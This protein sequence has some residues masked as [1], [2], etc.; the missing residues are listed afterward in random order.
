MYKLFEKK[1]LF[2]YILLFLLF[3]L[4]GFH[5]FQH[6]YQSLIA[7]DSFI[8]TFIIKPSSAN[9]HWVQLLVFIVFLVMFYLLTIVFNQ[10]S[11]TSKNLLAIQSIF[12]INSILALYFENDL[13]S[14]F[15]LFFVLLY[16]MFFVISDKKA[17]TTSLFFNI[18]FIFG[19]SIFLSLKLLL[20]LP[21]LLFSANIYGKNGFGDLFSF[22]FGLMVPIY[23]VSTFLYLSD[24]LILISLYSDSIIQLQYDMIRGK[25]IILFSLI[26]LFA[27]MAF[28]A[29]PTFNINTRKLYTILLSMFFI[30]VPFYIFLSFREN[31]SYLIL[32]LIGTLYL[33][34]FLS[35]SKKY[36]LKSFILF[37]GFVMAILVTI[38][39]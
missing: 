5:I 15:E 22:I 13:I 37:S 33:S 39:R 8:F 11:F 2:A 19:V 24:K 27:F 16:L 4:L 3:G 6:D 7:R 17:Q 18:G 26:S 23:I 25:E 31:K 20:L 32:S 30:L 12:L 10:L 14:I 28:P 1:T 34:A 9:I 36:K 35:T 38:I 21:I 29:I